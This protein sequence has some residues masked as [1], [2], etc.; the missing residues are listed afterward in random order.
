MVGRSY[1]NR[2]T[3]LVAIR[4]GRPGFSVLDH[5]R[6]PLQLKNT[7][8]RQRIL[9]VTQKFGKRHVAPTLKDK[10]REGN[11]TGGSKSDSKIVQQ[12]LIVVQ[13]D[14]VDDFKLEQVENKVGSEMKGCSVARNADGRNVHTQSRR[15]L[16]DD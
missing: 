4:H 1:V 11:K 10:L 13:Q 5:R 16:P 9:K 8:S 3:I 6:G 2:Y 14:T 7:L 12:V 15:K